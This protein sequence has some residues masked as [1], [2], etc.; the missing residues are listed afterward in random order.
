MV[1]VARFP[2]TVGLLKF[3]G[4]ALFEKADELA[5]VRSVVD[6]LNKDMNVIW[7]DAVGVET[8][9]V[10]CGAIEKEMQDA[11]GGYSVREM[12]KAVVT[13]NCYEIRLPAKVVFGS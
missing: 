7:H 11:S 12:R 13:A 3:E 6:S 5:E 4:G 8:K 9:R 10:A 2:E 1:V